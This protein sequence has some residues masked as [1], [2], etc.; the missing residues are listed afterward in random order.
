MDNTKI[1][2]PTIKRLAVYHR[3]LENMVISGVASVSSNDLAERLGIKASQVR[4]DLSYF[5]EFGKRGVGYSTK[6]LLDSISEILGIRK[7]WKTCIVGMGNLGMALANYPGLENS[8]F[9]SK[10]LFDN[11][12][13]KIGIP[14]PNDLVIE[15][16]E[17]LEEIVKKR[18]IEIG[19]ITVPAN[20]AQIIADLL[21]DAGVKGIVNFAPIRLTLPPGISNEEIDISVSFR[22]LA[23]N[24]TF[25]SSR[26]GRRA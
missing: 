22:S 15:S 26:K 5:G 2:K 19:V 1:P 13:N 17:V 12:P 25:G 11:N 21:A 9:I 23:F 3:C 14:M 18:Q 7:K 24:M 6:H 4:K 16:T 8:G 20:A 10:A